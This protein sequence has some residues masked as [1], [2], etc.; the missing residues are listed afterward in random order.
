MEKQPTTIN[1]RVFLSSAAIVG[2]SGA[3]SAGGL[4][5][6]CT[7]GGDSENMYTP[8]RQAG[9][10]YVPD[11]VDKAMDGRPLK[12]ALIGCGARGTGAAINFL[13]AGEG[14]SVVACADIIKER[15]DGCRARLKERKNIEIADEMCFLG[16]DAYKKACEAPG[17]DVVIIASPT[18]F[19]PDQAKYAVDMGKHVFCEKPAAVDAVGYRTY[20]MAVRQATAKGLSFITG[21]YAHHHRGYVESYKKVQEGYIGR[22]VSGVVY[23]NQS[24]IGFVRRRPEWTD[25]EY[26]VRDFFNWIWLSGDHIVD[27]LIHKLDVFVWFSH[28]K[29]V[30]AIGIGSRLRRFA[31]DNYDNFSADFEFEGD[32][33]V[34]GITRQI[35]NC[36]NRIGEIIQ[37]TKGSWSTIDGEFTIRDLDGHEV[38]KYDKEAEKTQYKQIDP[39]TLEHVNLVNHI[40]SGKPV[41]LGETTAISS[42]AL[43]M[44]RESAYTGNSFT[45]DEMTQSN[46]NLMPDELKMGNVDMSKF[47]RSLVPGTTPMRD[48]VWL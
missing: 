29:P 25:M 43:I 10:Y 16:F 37:G 7:N 45:W 31:G 3:L 42:M 8:L 47:V 11:L 48:P 26:M 41:N 21:T 23:L 18:L 44:A 22:I 34:H 27:N 46:L 14:L 5:T 19:H 2:A 13:N 20:M 30:R 24:D 40:R 28:L 9:D 32:V 17:V 12:A 38:W 6:A 4:F 39:Y 33:H 35:D 1:R 15:M 36:H